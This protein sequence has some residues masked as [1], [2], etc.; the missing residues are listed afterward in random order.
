MANP[1]FKE[2]NQNTNGLEQQFERFMKQMEG[3]NPNQMINQMLQ[4]GQINQQQLNMA[5]Q[6][7]QQLSGMLKK[8]MR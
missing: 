8:F 3:K 7:A 5:Q 1:L 4:S 2:M 6:R